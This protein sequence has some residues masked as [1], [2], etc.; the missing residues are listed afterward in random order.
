MPV[1]SAASHS[2]R[3]LGLDPMPIYV[4]FKV[5]K[6]ALGKIFSENLGLSLS[7]SLNQCSKHVF[8]SFNLAVKC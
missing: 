2:E 7:V 1:H 8:Y 6:E 5:D 4:G 3:T